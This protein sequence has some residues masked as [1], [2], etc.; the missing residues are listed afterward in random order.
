[1]KRS[2]MPPRTKPMLRTAMRRRPSTKSRIPARV[3]EA[4]RTRSGGRCEA[5]TEVCTGR[6][7]HMHHRRMRS[8]GGKHTTANL[9]DVCPACHRFIHDHPELSYQAGWLFPAWRLTPPRKDP[10]Q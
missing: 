1:M 5:G 7:G 10:A 6:A 2:P 9:L 8:Q 3:A 4:V